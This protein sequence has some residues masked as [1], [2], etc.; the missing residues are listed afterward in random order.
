[1][2][3]LLVALPAV[4]LIAI[5]AGLVGPLRVHVESVAATAFCSG[6]GSR[7]WIKDGRPVELVDLACFGRPTRLV[8]RK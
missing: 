4:T 3:A 2:C 7:A 6:C 1:M 8:W 5:E